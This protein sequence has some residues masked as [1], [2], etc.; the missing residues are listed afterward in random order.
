MVVLYLIKLLRSLILVGIFISFHSVQANEYYVNSSGNDEWTGIMHDS[1][2][3]KTDGP[4]KTL[5]RAKEAIRELKST[6][7]FDDKVTI[8]ISGG[9]YK[10]SSPLQFSELDTGLPGK[11]V[12]WQGEH[13]SKIMIS[14]GLTLSCSK[15]AS[16]LWECP[17]T[18]QPLNTEYY[19]T[20]RIKGNIPKFELFVNG[21]KLHLARWP[22][23][24]WAHIKLPLEK[25]TRFSVIETL[26]VLCEDIKNAQVHIFAGNDWFDQYV[27]IEST[28]SKNNSLKLLNTTDYP[29][30]SGR[31][32]NIQNVQALLNSPSEWFYD[33]ANKKIIFIPPIGI[34]PTEIIM[35]SLPNLFLV[36][37]VQNVIFKN[38]SFQYAAATAIKISGSNDVV[39]DQLDVNNIGGVGLEIKDGKNVLLTNSQIHHTGG[40][41]V[42][43][44]G[45]DKNTLIGSGHRI[46]NNH[47]FQIGT[48]LLT[49]SSGLAVH[50]VGVTVSHN[51]VEHGPGTG[52]LLTGNE[53]IIE[54]NEMHHLCSQ[55]SDCGAFYTWGEDW[56]WRGNVIRNNY[57]HDL[58]GEGMKSVNVTNN[59]V[60]YAEIGAVGVYLD[61]GASG[62]EV[63]HNI[64]EN[65]GALS[66]QVGGGRDNNIFN[67]YFKTNH[68]AIYLDDRWPKY[69]WGQNITHLNTSPYRTSL[70]QQKYPLLAAPMLNK[71]W[72][73]GNQIEHNIIVSGEPN[74]LALLYFVP[75]ASTTIAHNLVWATEAKPIVSYK[76]LDLNKQVTGGAWQQW[77]SDGIEKNSIV[78]DPCISLVGKRLVACATSPIKEID[79]QPIDTDIGLLE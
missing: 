2:L 77:V 11:E 20:K 13:G 38:M 1:N 66:I 25:D 5:E 64:F 55:A 57:I 36:E 6:G 43:V 37:G 47:I 54:K 63:S 50:G 46:Y 68:Y 4:F 9:E 26:P 17:L 71:T 44:S 14:G 76:I 53:H 28:D 10:L 19:D 21:Q 78:S 48:T 61:N 79:F 33:E 16:G 69:D 40:G 8:N 27:G 58:L 3:A 22:D 59:Q 74:G 75:K 31:R 49:Y 23:Q 42:I 35:S 70:W 34:N 12:T 41:G 30:T 15:Q 52:I 73:E 60:V 62:F 67:N 18:Q 72:P 45:G 51:L 39:L 65:A 29:L 24:G 56:T 7:L 32:F